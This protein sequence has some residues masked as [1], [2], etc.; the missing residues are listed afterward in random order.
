MVW[1]YLF[2]IINTAIFFYHYDNF[3][4]YTLQTVQG[5]YSPYLI[6][7]EG[8]SSNEIVRE[9]CTKAANEGDKEAINLLKIVD[10]LEG[11]T[12]TTTPTKPTSPSPV[13]GLV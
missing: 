1:L 10:E 11:K 9:L 2:C 6:K 5:N 12:I 7:T 8:K 3:D 4:N 13:C